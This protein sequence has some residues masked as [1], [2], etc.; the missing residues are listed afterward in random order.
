MATKGASKEQDQREVVDLKAKKKISFVG[1]GG[2]AKA[3]GYHLGVLTALEEYG[4]TVRGYGGK[5]EIV[6][7]IGSSA[8][9]LFGAFIVN[10]F[11]F[12]RIHQ[13]LEEKSFW[14]YFVNPTK[15]EKGKMYGLSYLDVFPP[16]IPNFSDIMDSMNGRQVLDRYK[17]IFNDIGELARTFVP[18]VMR[19]GDV[20]M[21]IEQALKN[22]N[23]DYMGIEGVLREFIRFSAFSNTDRLEKYLEDILEINDFQQLRRE[24]G[25]DFYV[26]ASE[27]NRPRKAI[28]GPRRSEFTTDPWADRYIDG[29][30]ISTACAASSSLPVL[31]RPKKIIIEGEKQY[32]VDGEVK[33]TLSTHVARECGADL[34]IVSHTLE[35][36]KYQHTK[37]S[38]TQHGLV[39]IL[40]QSIFIGVAQKI[41]SAWMVREL[42]HRIY[43]HIETPEF[44]KQLEALLKDYTNGDT[45]KLKKVLTDFL[46]DTVAELLKVDKNIQYIFIPSDNDVFWMDHFNI[47]PHYMKRL[48]NAG[49]NCAKKAIEENYRFVG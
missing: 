47:F 34:V 16:N 13:F 25:I 15:R 7:L 40:L 11:S 23:K 10:N 45:N 46:Q 41:K 17:H 22:A 14:R 38:L 39:S 12:D 32:Y 9:S 36:Y 5:H 27:L 6:D 43:D 33:Q 35:P 37:G 3:L 4:I 30:P 8:G 20:E 42:R 18:E 48:A 29:V 49:Y 31:Y 26:I 44:Q 2:A 24:R 28:F 19:T 21:S 1:S